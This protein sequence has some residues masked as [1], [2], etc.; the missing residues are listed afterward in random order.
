MNGRLLTPDDVAELLGVPRATL[1]QWRYKGIGP[2]GVRVG[3][4]VRYR[5]EDIDA[6][7]EHQ[8]D[9]AGGKGHRC[10]AS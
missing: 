2:R 6:W 4:Y 1:R 8:A 7:V 3:K 5:P 10:A 9:P